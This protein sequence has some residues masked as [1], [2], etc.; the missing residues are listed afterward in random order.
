MSTRR[1]TG[2]GLAFLAVSAGLVWRAAS[3]RASESDRAVVRTLSALTRESAPVALLTENDEVDRLARDATRDSGV[4][5]ITII[6]RDPDAIDAAA[7][8]GTLL[9]G[10]RG[11]DYLEALG[12]ELAWLPQ[13]PA[14]P[15]FPWARVHGRLRCAPVTDEAWSPLPGLEYTGRLGIVL[16]AGADG[17]MLLIVGDDLPLN[18]DVSGADGTYVRMRREFLPSVA[19]APPDYWLEG[20]SPRDAPSEVQQITLAATPD[21]DRL[22]SARLGRRAPRVLARLRGYAGDARATVCAAPTGADAAFRDA[23][24]AFVLVPDLTAYFATGWSGVNVV[25][26][27]GAVRWMG[28]AG[29]LLIPFARR[30]D[31]R[32]T[33][34]AH[35]GSD[36]GDGEV[37]LRINDLFDAPALPLRAGNLRYEW[38]VSAPAWAAGTNEVLLR[39]SGAGVD[40]LLGL[41]RLEL[42]LAP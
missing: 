32:V 11:R 42:S 41:V 37:S 33:L 21:R 13:D 5:P 10:E 15:S 40:R 18:I 34:Y 31:V 25:S 27:A 38:S 35:R 16:P 2:L 24:A 26:G 9:A 7:R 8:L 20:G 14:S 12:Y 17:A 4:P 1:V 39:V 19:A 28:R 23:A 36:A 6:P 22:I 30:G 3:G 29:A